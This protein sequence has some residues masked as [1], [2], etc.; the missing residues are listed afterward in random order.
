MSDTP[1][2]DEANKQ[3]Q[4][5]VYDNPKGFCV[6]EPVHA[7]FARELERELSHMEALIHQGDMLMDE[8]RKDKERL[9]WI[10]SDAG[11]YWLSSREDIDKEMEDTQTQRPKVYRTG[12]LR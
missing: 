12:I 4:V 9:D 2:T 10:L 1:R 6:T 8:L 5:D 7:S 11:K 3:Y